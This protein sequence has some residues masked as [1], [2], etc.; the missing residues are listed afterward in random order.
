MDHLK[1]YCLSLTKDL[2]DAEDL[3]QETWIKAHGAL[4]SKEHANPQALLLRIA[5]NTWIDQTRKQKSELLFMQQEKKKLQVDEASAAGAE[6]IELI[7][8]A[9]VQHLTPLQRAVFLLKDVYCFSIS[10]ISDRLHTTQGA[11]KAALHRARQALYGVKRDLE[12]N[13][14]PLPEEESRI[15][16]LRILAAA[17]RDGEIARVIELALH[18]DAVVLAVA[19]QRNLQ[20]QSRLQK[21]E[22]SGFH[23]RA[24]A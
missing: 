22:P 7:F 19:H 8:Q 21:G 12:E 24:A 20:L 23:Q 15:A 4:K 9:L 11:V 6:Q 10:E 16:Y 2:W 3:A 14:L 18:N 13:T 17:F 5:K 1:R